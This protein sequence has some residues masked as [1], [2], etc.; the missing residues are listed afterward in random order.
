[1]HRQR[2]PSSQE[3]GFIVLHL[4]VEVWLCSIWTGSGICRN[5]FA[6]LANFNAHCQI[7]VRRWTRQRHW[8]PTRNN[9]CMPLWAAT[10]GCT[11][12]DPPVIAGC[13]LELSSHLCILGR[14]YS[15]SLSVPCYVDGGWRRKCLQWLPTRTSQPFSFLLKL[16]FH[17][18]C[19]SISSVSGY[20]FISVGETETLLKVS[21]VTCIH[22]YLWG[23]DCLMAKW[24]HL[25]S[26]SALYCSMIINR[27]LTV[28]IT[29]P[30]LTTASTET[31]SLSPN[32]LLMR[33]DWRG[34]CVW[35]TEPVLAQFLF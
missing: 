10:I 25:S 9:Y 20:R 19:G 2:I 24:C 13:L 18:L 8:V 7:L 32:T 5:R 31:M 15:C 12:L 26:S 17:Q 16:G 34:C 22:G 21:K 33:A 29:T 4:L 30:P 1:M 23:V 14:P 27:H 11:I 28:I 6:W 3:E 35:E